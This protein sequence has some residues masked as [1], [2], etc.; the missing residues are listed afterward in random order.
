MAEQPGPSARHRT[1]PP[2]ADPPAAAELAERI[3]AHLTARPELRRRVAE[4]A[5]GDD[6]ASRRARRM[7][8]AK[9]EL[10]DLADRAHD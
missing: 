10:A 3:R 1:D 2:A 9:A 5:V 4:L 7:A 6:P 8:Q